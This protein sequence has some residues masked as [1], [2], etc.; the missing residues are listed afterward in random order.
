MSGISNQLHI[1]DLK[2]KYLEKISMSDYSVADLR[3]FFAGK[4]LKDDLF[5]YT[6]DI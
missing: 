5:I 4:E 1:K 3:F 2:Q 6:Y